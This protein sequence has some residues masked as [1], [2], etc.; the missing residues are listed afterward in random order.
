MK[1]QNHEILKKLQSKVP[2]SPS[3]WADYTNFSEKVKNIV[4]YFI[5]N[6]TIEKEH[7]IQILSLNKHD[8]DR[9]ELFK[10]KELSSF[11]IIVRKTVTT[12]D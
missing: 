9:E 6:E 2:H 7:I 3:Q 5:S 11:Q 10:V 12:V 4:N 1:L 8:K